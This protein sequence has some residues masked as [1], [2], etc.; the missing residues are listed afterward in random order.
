MSI[1]HVLYKT[2]MFDVPQ[3]VSPFMNS[4]LPMWARV[5]SSV[6]GAYSSVALVEEVPQKKML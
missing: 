5:S 4:P 2:N 3:V 1:L 6:T